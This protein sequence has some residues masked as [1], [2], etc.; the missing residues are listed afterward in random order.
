MKQGESCINKRLKSVKEVV[1]SR[2]N[3]SALNK[4]L[5]SIISRGLIT[6]KIT[7][8]WHRLFDIIDMEIQ[9]VVQAAITEKEGRKK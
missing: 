6:G 1:G 3:S 5:D 2:F 7:L 4:K 9:E 8:V